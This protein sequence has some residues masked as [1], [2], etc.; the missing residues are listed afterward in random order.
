[1][2]SRR[3]QR[4]FQKYIGHKAAASLSSSAYQCNHYGATTG[5][6]GVQFRCFSATSSSSAN[7]K[8]DNAILSG[9]QGLAEELWRGR[10]LTGALR[11][12]HASYGSYG[13]IENRKSWQM[14]AKNV[15][16][17]CEIPRA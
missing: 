6:H 14:F 5:V 16:I 7:E 10:D 11:A 8:L 12:A 4:S 13:E 9:R 17:S 2:R 1:M 3:L 15:H